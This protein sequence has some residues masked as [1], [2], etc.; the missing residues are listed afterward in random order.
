MFILSHF[1][2]SCFLCF[3][4][5][6][7]SYVVYVVFSQKILIMVQLVYV[8]LPGHHVL[9]LCCAP[10]AKLC[11]IA[12]LLVG[13]GAVTGVDINLERLSSTRTMC[14]KYQVSQTRLFLADG[15]TF[16]APPTTT[17]ISADNKI[18]I[19]EINENGEIQPVIR[20]T[21]KLKAKRKS[22]KRREEFEKWRKTQ[23]GKV[24]GEHTTNN[25]SI[26]TSSTSPLLYDRVLVDAECTHDGSIKHILKYRESGFKAIEERLLEPERLKSLET[27]QRKLIHNGFNQLKEGGTMIYSTCSFCRSQNEDIVEWLLNNEPTAEL[28]P[29]VEPL[30][31]SNSDSSVHSLSFNSDINSPRLFYR[32]G[33]S[34]STHS[35]IGIKFDPQTSGTSGLYIA[36]IRKGIKT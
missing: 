28:V 22:D 26:T 8:V 30:T 32:V 31:V 25:C 34:S 5:V 14:R 6:M 15:C 35:S 4:P 23:E 16:S 7:R 12:D 2:I 10:G 1:T 33:L 19:L 20:N 11:L 9:D 36:K 29:T 3:R 21:K 13:E 18:E 27:L 24:E 17:Q